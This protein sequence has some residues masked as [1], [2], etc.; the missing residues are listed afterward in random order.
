MKGFRS[1]FFAWVHFTWPYTSVLH[2]EPASSLVLS[3]QLRKGSSSQPVCCYRCHWISM[4]NF[5][6]CASIIGD[7][8][9]QGW[10]QASLKKEADWSQRRGDQKTRQ[11]TAWKFE[12]THLCTWQVPRHW[13][14]KPQTW[15][16]YLNQ[17]RHG[18]DW[19]EASRP[20]QDW[21][22]NRAI[23]NLLWQ[24]EWETTSKSL[25]GYKLRRILPGVAFPP[26]CCQDRGGSNQLEISET[27]KHTRLR[28]FLLDLLQ[29]QSS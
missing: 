4:C 28:V 16:S 3:W 25:R 14:K 22:P 8:L 17:N 24:E 12:Q 11:E 19:E 1:V 23:V 15:S 21:S 27:L 5:L 7:W 13:D 18:K 2:W 20:R 29:N 9:C 10:S 6:Q 26:Y